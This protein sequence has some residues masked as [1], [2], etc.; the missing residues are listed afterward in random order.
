[1]KKFLLIVLI[2]HFSFLISVP[3]AFAHVTVKPK[4]VPAA[5]YQV[6]TVSVPV[7]KNIPTT[8]VRIV[9]PEGIQ[10]V[11]PNVKSGWEIEVQKEGEGEAAKATA[12]IWSGGTIPAGQRDEFLFSTQAPATEGTL[13]WKAYQTYEDGTVVAWDQNPKEEHEHSHDGE[14]NEEGPWSETT[15][16]NNGE[17]PATVASEQRSVKDQLPLIFSIAALLL[18]GTSVWMQSRKKR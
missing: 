3:P 13:T 18:A 17:I 5:E 16:V 15:I 12:I 8:E 14:T 4:T 10:S 9:L 6:F 11:T 1:M 7:E 2:A